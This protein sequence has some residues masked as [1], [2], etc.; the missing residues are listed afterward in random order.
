VTNS[1]VVERA[2]RLGARLGQPK[3][4]KTRAQFLT[5]L[6]RIADRGYGGGTSQQALDNVR[7]LVALR[8]HW[9]GDPQVQRALLEAWESRRPLVTYRHLKGQPEPG[10]GQ[11]WRFR[12][13][14]L[15]R[16]GRPLGV[17]YAVTL[18]HGGYLIEDGDGT[19]YST[20][21]AAGDALAEQSRPTGTSNS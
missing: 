12:W 20:R 3:D 11:S 14:V 19:S 1:A 13:Q 9:E 16:D 10:T 7:E 21:D 5:I 8:E 18:L 6:R 2:R 15:H 4:E 17:V